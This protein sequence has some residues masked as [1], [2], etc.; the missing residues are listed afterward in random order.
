MKLTRDVHFGQCGFS[1]GKN[2]TSPQHLIQRSKDPAPTPLC[3]KPHIVAHP[4]FL[5]KQTVS[6][7]SLIKK[8]NDF[9]P[10]EK[11]KLKRKMKQ[12]KMIH[13]LE[14]QMVPE[15]KILFEF[16]LE[17]FDCDINPSLGIP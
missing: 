2:F 12:K 17:K 7:E 8:K 11:K 13:F 10:F 4:T 6:R 3:K 14:D 9:G 16:F 1:V 5:P 15:L